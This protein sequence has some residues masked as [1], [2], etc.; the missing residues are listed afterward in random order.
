MSVYPQLT[1]ENSTG[2]VARGIAAPGPSLLLPVETSRDFGTLR[3]V[4]EI[5]HEVLRGEENE[6]VLGILGALPV[7]E[8]LEL[9]SEIR[10]TGPKLFSEGD[11]VLNLGLRQELT[12]HF[13]L[14]ASAGTGLNN[15]FNRTSFIAYL[16][17]QIVLGEEKP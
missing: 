13:K 8:R 15:G 17:I 16:G 4:G 2:S 3:V 12:P 11:V 6:W 1:V 9:L 5:G 10:V 7:S 14:L